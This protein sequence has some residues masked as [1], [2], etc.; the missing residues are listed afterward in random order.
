MAEQL[1][2]LVGEFPRIDDRYAMAAHR[3][4]YLLVSDDQKPAQFSRAGLF[5]NTLAHVDLA[6]RATKTWWCGPVSSLQEPAF[7]P[8][9]ANSPE[10]AG[11]IVMLCNRLAELRSDLLLFDAQ[12]VDEGPIATLYL[13]LR[14]R[15]GLH[16]NWHPAQPS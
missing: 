5:M 10:G 4:G 1:C 7:I 14:L 9:S 16:G 3:H 13:P 12:H 15:P 8:R 11:Y 2:D 6:T